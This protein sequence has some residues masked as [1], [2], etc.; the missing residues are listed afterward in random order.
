MRRSK[1]YDELEVND[2][3]WF[4]GAKLKIIAIRSFPY[5][6]EAYKDK[7]DVVINFD[8]IPADDEAVEL[9]GKFYSHGTYGGVG[10]LTA[11]MA[12]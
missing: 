10:C 2:L 9:L 3:I 4:Y 1:R 6:E 12:D 11:T 7:T 8:V 5:T